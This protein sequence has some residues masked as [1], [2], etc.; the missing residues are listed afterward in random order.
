MTVY[1]WGRTK[2]DTRE[3][4]TDHECRGERVGKVGQSADPGLLY[5]DRRDGVTRSHGETLEGASTYQIGD[6]RQV[7]QG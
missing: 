3:K 1:F 5:K 2:V 4:S 6:E 7:G